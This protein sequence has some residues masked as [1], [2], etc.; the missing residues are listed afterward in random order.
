MPTDNF[1]KIPHLEVYVITHNVDIIYLSET[2]LYRSYSR[3]DQ[4]LQSSAYSLIRGDH[5]I[6]LKRG[7]VCIFFLRSIFL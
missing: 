1:V 3:D 2:V 7:G 6:D 5:P 4:I